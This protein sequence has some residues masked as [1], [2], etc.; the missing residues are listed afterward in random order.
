MHIPKFVSII[1]GL[2]GAVSITF[3]ISTTDLKSII[4]GSIAVIGAILMLIHFSKKSI[5][6][7]TEKSTWVGRACGNCGYRVKEY[8]EII[9]NKCPQCKHYDLDGDVLHY[10]LWFLV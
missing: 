6:L 5:K 10:G 3:G 2:G 9:N 1:A 8:D 4:G 7:D